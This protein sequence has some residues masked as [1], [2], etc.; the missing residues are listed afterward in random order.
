MELTRVA[1][2]R[3]RLTPSDNARQ[4]ESAEVASA[5]P[6][7]APPVDLDE[8]PVTRPFL[9]PL[10]EF[11]PYLEQIW[12][13]RWLTNCGPF[14]EQLEAEL[15]VHLGVDH[16][17]LTSNGTTAL[18]MAFQALDL[19]GEVITTPFTFVATAH[20]LRACNLRPVFVDIDPRTGNLDPAKIEQAITSDTS[21]I[22]PVHCFGHP[23]QTNRIAAIAERHSLKVVY[24]AAQAF[25]VRRD[26]ESLLRSGDA[27]CV[28]FHATKVFN[29]F[30]GG[31]VICPD[32]RTKRRIAQLRNFG[33]T[34]T[35][36]VDAIGTNAKMNEVQAAFGLLQLKYVDEAISR[37]GAIA[38]RYAATLRS[39]E[40]IE[41][42]EP[43][44]GWQPNHSYFPMLLGERIADQR[45]ALC[46]RLL[47]AGIHSRPYFWPLVTDHA[48]YR[49]VPS[50]AAELLVA[51]DFARRV[52]CLPLY[53]DL[54]VRH[55]DNAVSIVAEFC[56]AET[57][58]PL[59]RAAR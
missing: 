39:L 19:Q 14:H 5:I 31:A 48:V 28:S 15:A 50:A 36:S 35:Y 56:Q 27:A 13:N 8:A 40:D 37:R 25:G 1:A 18:Q 21:A 34:D 42:F 24:D 10:E 44:A 2:G 7:R 33:F 51:R 54:A 9:P 59:A 49:H 58:R 6:A 57:S 46:A 17:A 12:K 29:T 32:V 43:E 55:V 38:A 30:E 4:A 3:R 41:L 20:A 53:P 11:Q 52:L 45:D 26:G 22:L 16:L 47:A 23:C